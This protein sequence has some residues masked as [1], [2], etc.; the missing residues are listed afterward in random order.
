MA[1]GGIGQVTEVPWLT[2][3]SG[4][5]A[6]ATPARL[7]RSMVTR[8]WVAP[9]LVRVNGTV[10]P[11]AP[12]APSVTSPSQ[13]LTQPGSSSAEAGVAAAPI[14]AVARTSVVSPC[15]SLPRVTRTDLIDLLGGG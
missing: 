9:V 14:I 4:K 12:A 7:V 13:P 5:L 8:G 2:Q 3:K 6:V 15:T 11:G 1:V 10:R